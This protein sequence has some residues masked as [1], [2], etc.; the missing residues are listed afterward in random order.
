MPFEADLAGAVQEKIIV[1]LPPPALVAIGVVATAVAQVLLKQAAPHEI[2]S[3]PWLLFMGLAA[4]SYTFSFILY[5]RVLQHY[6]LNKV[7]PAMTVAQIILITLYGLVVGEVIDARHALGLLF[8][9]AS[10]Y[11]ILS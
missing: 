1:T 11:L 3:T 7:Y 8:G 10:I 6:P 5:S 2:R 4:A 9:I